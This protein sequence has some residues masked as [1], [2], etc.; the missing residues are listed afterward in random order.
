M[1]KSCAPA[2]AI[3][4]RRFAVCS[5]LMFSNVIFLDEYTDCVT[6]GFLG[7]AL[8]FILGVFGV[9]LKY[10]ISSWRCENVECG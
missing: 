5:P 1:I 4:A 3:V 7:D 8:I 2:A 6:A 9:D 10:V